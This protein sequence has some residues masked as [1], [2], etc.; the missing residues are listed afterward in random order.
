AIAG[1]GGAIGATGGSNGDAATGTGG[2]SSDGATDG[3]ADGATAHLVSYT[4]DGTTTDGWM[5]NNFAQTGNIGAPDAG[6][7]ISLTLDS[8]AGDPAG[9]LS[10]SGTFTNYNQTLDAIV[11]F[12]TAKDL[13]GKTLHARVKLDSGTIAFA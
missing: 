7:G 2:S 3:N 4:F 1:T 6:T 9:S 11:N 10:M 5:I 13:T 8:A 12:A